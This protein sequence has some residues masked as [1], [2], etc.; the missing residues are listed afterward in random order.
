MITLTERTH[1]LIELLFDESNRAE[2]ARL[3]AQDCGN[4]LHFLEELTPEGLERFR[5]AALKISNGDIKKLRRAIQ[6]AN[7]DWRDLLMG[8]GFGHS[9]SEHERWAEA[10]LQDA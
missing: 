7:E 10:R 5:F 6:V 8:A 3:L 9:L 2:V 4:N 1:K